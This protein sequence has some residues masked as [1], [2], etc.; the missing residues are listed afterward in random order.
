MK[1]NREDRKEKKIFVH[2]WLKNSEYELELK[3]QEPRVKDQELRG[4]FT[5]ERFRR[6][7]LNYYFISLYF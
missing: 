2:S 1:E 6:K 4:K 5:S 7:M 3:S